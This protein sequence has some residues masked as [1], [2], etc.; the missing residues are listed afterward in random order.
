VRDSLTRVQ[1]ARTSAR[2]RDAARRGAWR[3]AGDRRSSRD[4]LAERRGTRRERTPTRP[5]E[6]GTTPLSLSLSLSLSLFLFLSLCQVS[7]RVGRSLSHGTIV[8]RNAERIASLSFLQIPP[9]SSL[10]R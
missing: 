10:F 8:G 3:R 6:N 2:H 4:R 5:A 9:R 7:T 1:R